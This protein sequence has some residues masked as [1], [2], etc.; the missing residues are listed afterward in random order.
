MAVQKP[1]ST[2]LELERS[3]SSLAKTVQLPWLSTGDSDTNQTRWLREVVLRLEEA[4]GLAKI[5]R[6]TKRADDLR[7]WCWS[8]ADAGDWEAALSAFAQAAE[9]VPDDDHARRGLL[10]GAAL[11]A[12]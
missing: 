11:A 8:L 5:A 7:A 9:F 6:S 10:D 12:N 4:D 3:S 2:T 1:E